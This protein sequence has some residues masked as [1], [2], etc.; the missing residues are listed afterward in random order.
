[1]KQLPGLLKQE[2]EAF[3][4]LLSLDIQAFNWKL[5][6]DCGKAQKFLD[7]FV[8]FLHFT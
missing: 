8:E 5:A 6:E 1:M 3:Q 4:C 2:K 7:D